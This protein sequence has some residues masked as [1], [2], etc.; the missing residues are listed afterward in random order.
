M[1]GC[2]R[3][4]EIG[5][6]QY[7]DAFGHRYPVRQFY[8]SIRDIDQG[9]EIMHNYPYTRAMDDTLESRCAWFRHGGLSHNVF[10]T[11]EIASKLFPGRD[12]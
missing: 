3:L 5:S 2:M 9:E 6:W 11:L 12:S 1:L 4:V 10:E 8:V 7:K